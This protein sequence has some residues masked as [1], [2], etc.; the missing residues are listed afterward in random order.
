MLNQSSAKQKFYASNRNL[1]VKFFSTYSKTKQIADCGVFKG[2]CQDF[3]VFLRQLTSLPQKNMCLK[4][5][6]TVGSMCSEKMSFFF[7]LR[8]HF[9]KLCFPKSLALV[10]SLYYCCCS[11]SVLLSKM[12]AFTA[13]CAIS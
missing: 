12:K 13:V 7:L 4:A 10:R 1:P 5:T 2:F 6:E 9:A 3:W 11:G 8:Y